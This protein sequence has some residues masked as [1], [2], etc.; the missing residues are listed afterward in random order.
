MKTLRFLLVASLPLAFAAAAPATVEQWG[1]FEVALDG[2]SRGHPFA[3]VELAARFTH[4]A[5]QRTLTATGFYD[6][7][8][9]YRIRFMP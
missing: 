4:A 2:P 5:D 1:I 7:G 9:V 3:E 6:G 8:G